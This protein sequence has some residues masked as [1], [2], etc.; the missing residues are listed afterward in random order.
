MPVAAA[1][2]KTLY[3]AE[4]LTGKRASKGGGAGRTPVWTYEVQWKNGPGGKV[5]ANTFEPSDCL[6]GWEREMAKVDTA[7][8]ARA[9]QS[10]LKPV[11]EKRQREEKQATEKA[12]EKQAHKAR[13]SVSESTTCS[14][15]GHA[16]NSTSTSTL[17]GVVW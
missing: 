5:Y 9:T 12:V 7:V 13:A 11:A 17:R 15:P 16:G 2:D 14:E 6:V 4:R 10:F 1:P 8:A 3:V